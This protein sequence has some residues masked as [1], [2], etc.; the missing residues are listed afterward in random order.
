MAGERW[1]RIESTKISS[2]VGR[3]GPAENKAGFGQGGRAGAAEP[4]AA[5]PPAPAPGAA[6]RIVLAEIL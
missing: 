5:L 1:S 6:I 2:S 4:R 3:G